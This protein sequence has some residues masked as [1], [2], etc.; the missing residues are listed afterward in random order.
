MHFVLDTFSAAR[1]RTSLIRIIGIGSPFGDDAAGLEVADAL[2]TAPPPGCDVIRADR[3][4]AS[5]VE[6]LDGADAAIVIDAAHSGAP[7]GTLLEFAFDDLERSAAAHLV[8]SH[9]L[10]VA[11]AI[12]LARKLGRAPAR[13]RIL[14]IEV[15]GDSHPPLGGLSHAARQAVQR[16]LA[17]VRRLAAEL[18]EELR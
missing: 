6:M 5:L 10:G 4:G 14:A 1:D 16:A 2:A 18:N 11:A 3:P 13:G 7:P 17:R 9:D 8:S 12:A 15:P